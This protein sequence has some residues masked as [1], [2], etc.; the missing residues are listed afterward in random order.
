MSLRA[1]LAV[2]L[3]AASAHAQ[4]RLDS[5][6]G[7]VEVSPAG[8]NGA[9]M[10]AKPPYALKN[11]DRVRTGSDGSATLFFPDRTKV[12]L[13]PD[14]AFAVEKADKKDAVVKLDAGG[15]HAWVTKAMSR[16]FRVRS[17]SAVAAVR[18]TEFTVDVTA[19]QDTQ[20]VVDEG[21]VAVRIKSGEQTEL[22]NGRSY[23]SLLVIPGRPLSLL[24]HPREDGNKKDK[25]SA[26]K[27]PD[28]L[29]D[30]N[31]A[32]KSSVEAIEA[33]QQSARAKKAKNGPLSS[34]DAAE[35]RAHDRDEIKRFLEL[36]GQLPTGED[37]SGQADAKPQA[38]EADPAAGETDPDVLALRR[39]IGEGEDKDSSPSFSQAD[40]AK[41][42]QALAKQPGGGDPTV[43]AALGQAQNGGQVSP[44]VL[45]TLLNALQ[46][47]APAG[48]PVP[49]DTNPP[50]PSAP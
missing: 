7:K 33:C 5:A 44:E 50:D 17:P 1:A 35:L 40:V 49:T 13:G 10:A 31:G 24:P 11:G 26:K 37:A 15:L 20:I 47:Q 34:S 38:A 12:A 43:Q 19:T 3:C 4:A 42:Q 21:V 30:A 22:G 48:V 46:K 39:L 18:G 16:H 28:C 23:R 14:S 8:M 6:D 45:K 32:L 25:K 27:G 2:L 29:H 9:W 36:T 41:L